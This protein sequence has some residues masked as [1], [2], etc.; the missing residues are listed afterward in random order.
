MQNDVA[1]IA[2]GL[3][4][5]QR[6]DLLVRWPEFCDADPLSGGRDQ[7]EFVADML[8]DDFIRL[9]DVQP[10]DLDDPFAWERGI[11]PGGMVYVL[12]PLGE[13]LR[14]HLLTEVSNHER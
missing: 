10:D 13:A 9:R 4:P 2:R 1:T 6:D 7:D 3:N 8:L 5:T 11:E 12:T 14:A